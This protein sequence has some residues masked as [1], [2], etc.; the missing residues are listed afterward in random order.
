MVVGQ[1]S[2]TLTSNWS[3]G[4][5]FSSGWVNLDVY[6]CSLTG[7]DKTWA[8]GSPESTIQV[9]VNTAQS[10][11]ASTL[12]LHEIDD[13]GHFTLS[14]TAYGANSVVITADPTMY[15]T[16]HT[17]SIQGATKKTAL[18]DTVTFTLPAIGGCGVQTAT[19][20]VSTD[21]CSTA[22]ATPAI[23]S[24]SRSGNNVTLN[25]SAVTTNSDGSGP[26]T[27]LAGYKVY[28]ANTDGTSPASTT[29]APT[30]TTVKIN[31]G[32][33]N[34]IFLI[35]AYDGCNLESAPSN[36]VTR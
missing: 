30:E 1:T 28:Y 33:G 4:G 17:D 16:S 22:P 13:T 27:D 23:S 12:T 5:W 25:W 8:K 14:G 18:S 11:E 3:V 15:N 2:V 34:H 7:D 9:T 20:T 24:S 36:Q 31:A 10:V 6:I 29:V 35:K 19:L 21:P 32:N 26:I